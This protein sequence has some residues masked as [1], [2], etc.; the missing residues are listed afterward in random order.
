M[1]APIPP[2]QCVSCKH[3]RSDLVPAP[4]QDPALEIDYLDSCDAFPGGIPEAISN[5]EHDHRQPYEGDHGIRFEPR[6]G[7]KHPL[8]E[9]RPR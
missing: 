3:L 8:E 1:G 2:L 6:P 5:D 9:D 4:D 7:W